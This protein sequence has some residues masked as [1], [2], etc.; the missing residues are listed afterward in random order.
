[1]RCEVLGDGGPVAFE[2]HDSDAALFGAC[3]APKKTWI[4]RIPA[5]GP[6]E[7]LLRLTAEEGRPPE[8]V[9]LAWDEE[10]RK[11]WGASPDTGLVGAFEPGAEKLVLN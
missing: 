1:M 10:R 8:L 9:S 4:S 2:G 11:L 7:V 3:M 6:A 5:A